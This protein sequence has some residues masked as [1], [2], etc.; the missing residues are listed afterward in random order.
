MLLRVNVEA[1]MKAH[2]SML[3]IALLTGA[4]VNRPRRP[5]DATSGKGTGIVGFNVKM[6][7]DA[8][9]HLWLCTTSPIPA[10]TGRSWCPGKECITICGH[11]R[12]D[13][14]AAAVHAHP[15]RHSKL[16]GSAI[17]SPSSSSEGTCPEAP[18][19]FYVAA[20]TTSMRFGSPL[21]IPA[22]MLGAMSLAR[23]TR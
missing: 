21:A 5:L 3:A 19:R 15:A 17:T 2:P 23:V 11:G 22:S 7:V 18:R 20:M 6:A 9:H 14:S 12:E 1:P 10:A 13:D 4:L 16:C 8:E